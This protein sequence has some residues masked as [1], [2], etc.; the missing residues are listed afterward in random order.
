MCWVAM[1][2]AVPVVVAAF[3]VPTRLPGVPVSEF[4]VSNTITT[5]I[6]PSGGRRLCDSNQIAGHGLKRFSIDLP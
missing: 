3:V 6:L 2:E 4:R 1:V 5:M